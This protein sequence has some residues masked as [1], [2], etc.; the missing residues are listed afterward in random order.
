MTKNP[1]VKSDYCYVN[2]KNLPTELESPSVDFE[3]PKDDK[4]KIQDFRRRFVFVI[5]ISTVASDIG[6]PNYVS[7]YYI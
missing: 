3:A 6:F 2:Y 4:Y 7:E 5:D 1:S